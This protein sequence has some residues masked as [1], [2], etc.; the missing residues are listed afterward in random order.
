MFLEQNSRKSLSDPTRI[1]A[2]EL[3]SKHDGL[4]IRDILEA[5]SKYRVAPM[6]SFSITGLGGT[7]LEGGVMKYQD[8]LKKVGEL[9]ENGTLNAVTT[10]IRIDPILPGVTDMEDIKKIVQTAK[11]FGIRK[12]VT[13]LV[14][15]YGYLDGTP[16]DR[17]V[18]SG[19]N[20]ALASE[21]KTYD[22]DK[23][24]GRDR[25]GK[26]NFKPKQMYI[27]E[28]GKVLLELD[29]DPEISIQTCAFGINGLKV[30]AC[31]DPLIIERVVGVDVTRSDGTYERDTSRPECMC[32]GCHGDFFKAKGKK[33]Y[34][35]CAYCYAAHSGDNK[36]NYYNADGTL[37]DN[38]YTRTSR[39]PVSVIPQSYE[40]MITP[41]ANTIFVFGSNPEGRHGA[42]AAKTAREKFGAQY[43][44]GEGLQGNSYA[45]PTKDLRVREN[46]SLRSIAPWQIVESI[47]K[48]Y[49]VA[50][51]NPSK[52]F[53]VAYTN[54]LNETTLNGYTGAE[55]IRMFK[56]AGP[57]PNN[58]LFSKNWTDHWNEVESSSNNQQTSDAA[59]KQQAPV[60]KPETVDN[61]PIDIW[62]K[63]HNGYEGLSNLAQRP[64]VLDNVL[65]IKLLGEIPNPQIKAVLTK[66]LS[67][68]GNRI[69]I[70]SVENL[71][72]AMKLFYSDLYVKNNEFTAEGEK[73]FE[74]IIN[75]IP[76]IA[77]Y[78]GGRY[79]DIKNLDSSSWDSE[80]EAIMKVIAKHSFD[81]NPGAKQLLLSTGNR[82]LT[83]VKGDKI[84]KKA[85]PRV[86]MSIRHEYQQK[87][88][89]DNNSAP[90]R[91]LQATIAP[92][93]KTEVTAQNDN[94]MKANVE[95]SFK[96]QAHEIA[97]A[98]GIE[99]EDRDI[100]TNIQTM[101][102]MEG[103]TVEQV[104]A[105]LSYTFEFSGNPD[106]D[107]VRI[108]TALMADLGYQTQETAAMTQYVAEDDV[109]FNAVEY[110]VK[111]NNLKGVLPM[112]DRLGFTDYR[113]NNTRKEVTILI[114]N[115]NQNID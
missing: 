107:K 24:Y 106:I 113:V 105:Q 50:R 90:V 48:M 84:W 51:Q 30:S 29:K 15:S 31:L 11:S 8:M 40:G 104:A 89:S 21:G 9:I 60:P 41:D 43:G 25:D 65:I 62:S 80:S 23:Y 18:T 99:L 14:Q 97:Q 103:N 95:Q 34:S 3:W 109:N 36:L 55:M 92:Y 70:N 56:E 45:I 10:T 91:T 2:I 108:F 79:G 59:I 72:Q 64:Y 75:A 102:N 39:E 111:V 17:H 74:E 20:N 82:Q 49:K 1:T 28:I 61:G 13:S 78:K 7:A 12:F 114:S 96:Q 46:N 110:T 58:V 100:S 68:H 67:K 87:E 69:T 85:F 27:D 52:Q 37:K 22:W 63:N 6:V 4:P 98:L 77:K 73:L 86:L 5:C 54:G 32:Y 81:S 35:S 76:E 101:D 88:S 71:F 93:A 83:H 33:C 42:G 94:D 47:K 44:Q 115:T 53:K 112:L 66:Y 16:R 19:I 38:D 57:I 26:I